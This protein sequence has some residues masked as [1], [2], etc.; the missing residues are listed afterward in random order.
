M[1]VY[2][3]FIYADWQAVIHNCVNYCLQDNVFI[4]E[5]QNGRRILIPSE[6]VLL[7]GDYLDYYDMT[8]NVF[9]EWEE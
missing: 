8:G 7:I 9:D 5:K 2:V 4:I 3:R 1:T 6:N